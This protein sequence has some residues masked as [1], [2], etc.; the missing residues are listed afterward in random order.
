[1]KIEPQSETEFSRVW[2]IVTELGLYERHLNDIES[3]YRILASTWLLATFTGMGFVVTALGGDL[4]QAKWLI[5]SALAAAGATGVL[6]L[7]NL[8]LRVYHRLLDAVF[9]QALS[10]EESYPWLPQV[11]RAI[12]SSQKSGDVVARIVWFYIV[13]EVVL[14]GIG[15]GAFTKWAAATELPYQSTFAGLAGWAVALLGVATYT[16]SATPRRKKLGGP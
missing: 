11:R 10:L 16:Y 15:G 4:G 5:V 13:I 7:W 8:D 1:M 3:R 2:A 14:I 12:I 6:L 9:I